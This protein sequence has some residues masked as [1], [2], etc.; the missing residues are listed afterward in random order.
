MT[1]LDSF[2]TRLVLGLVIAV[3]VLLAHGRHELQVLQAVASAALLLWVVLEIRHGYR[4][5][6]ASRP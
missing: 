6:H 3:L 5:R 2:G 1:R 4:S